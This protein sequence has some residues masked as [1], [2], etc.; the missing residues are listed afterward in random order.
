MRAASL[1]VALVLGA[2]MPASAQSL[3]TFTWQLQPFCNRVT[4]SVTQNGGIYTLDGYDDQCGAPQRAP[5]VGLAMPN[6]DGTIGLGF[7][8]ATAPGGKAVSVESRISLATIGGPWTDGAGNTGTLVLNG[9]AAGSPRPAPPAGGVTVNSVTS[10]SIVDGSV[11]AAD[12]DNAQVQLRLSGA[13]PTGQFMVGSAVSGT[14]TCSD[15]AASGS[16]TSTALGTNAL[17]N[18]ASGGRSTAIGANALSLNGSGGIGNTALGIDAM[19]NNTTGASNVA[20]GD[21]AMTDNISG[22]AHVAVGGR[23]LWHNVDGIRSVAIGN[24][25]LQN[26][27]SG[28]YNVAIGASALTTNSNSDHSVAIGESALY[29]SFNGNNTAV[30][31]RALYATSGSNN[32]A[33]GYLAGSA[34]GIGLNNVH[35]ANTG[36]IGDFGVMRLG[37]A[38]SQTTTYVSGVRGVTVATG[39]PVIIGTDGQLGTTTSSRRFKQDIADMSDFSARLAALRPVTFR[40]TQPAADGSRPLDFGLIAEE[41]AE[42][43]PEL[44]VRSADGQIETVA[45]HKLPALLLNELQKQQRLIDTLLQRV[46][47]LETA[48]DRQ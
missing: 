31:Y 28:N 1:L 4:V 30:G 13:C 43:F 9:A 24:A 40:Y 20:V 15:G 12:V 3:G 19:R 33:L 22:G 46:Q 27:V 34:V 44:A 14:V 2:A 47:L 11:T 10:T 7:H 48:R 8:I 6:P 39:I 23:A 5:L 41:V 45:Y 38:G 37:T 25:A 21:Q 17:A 35:I 16:N 36:L 42:V 32:T 26:N 29:N 18:G